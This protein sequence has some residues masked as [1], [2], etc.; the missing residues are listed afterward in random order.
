MALLNIGSHQPKVEGLTILDTV[1]GFD[2]LAAPTP[3]KLIN[4]GI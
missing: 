2:Q 4:L 3:A 1:N